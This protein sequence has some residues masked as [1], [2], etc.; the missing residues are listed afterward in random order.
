MRVFVHVPEALIVLGAIVFFVRLDGTGR[1][2][3]CHAKHVMVHARRGF[4]VGLVVSVGQMKH[5]L[6]KEPKTQRSTSVWRGVLGNLYQK[7]T[8]LHL[9]VKILNTGLA[10]LY[11]VMTVRLAQTVNDI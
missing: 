11:A 4:I 1:I 8:T 6:R 10:L 7:V 9:L 5:V 2:L 3:D